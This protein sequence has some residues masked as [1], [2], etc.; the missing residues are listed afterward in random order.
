[1]IDAL[2]RSGASTK[3]VKYTEIEGENHDSSWLTAFDDDLYHWLI[4]HSG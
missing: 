4:K 3:K 2:I 1:M